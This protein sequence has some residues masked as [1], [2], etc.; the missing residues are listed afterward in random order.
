[1]TKKTYMQPEIV[2][3]EMDGN[4]SICAGSGDI[5]TSKDPAK[6]EPLSL[7]DEGRPVSVSWNGSE[8]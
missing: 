7:G 1:M 2:A 8:E 5:G 3:V 4:V 6:E